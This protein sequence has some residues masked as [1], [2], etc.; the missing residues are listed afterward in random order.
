M[1]TASCRSASS[2]ESARPPAEFA[3][4]ALPGP[5]KVMLAQPL[6][7]DLEEVARAAGEGTLR[8]PIA[9]VVPLAEGIEALTDLGLHRTAKRGK[10]IITSG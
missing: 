10:L 9:R 8:L 6:T 3:R 5:N 7:T 1:R 2:A 4:S